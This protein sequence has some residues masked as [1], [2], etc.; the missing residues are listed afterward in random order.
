MTEI[1]Q[2]NNPEERLARVFALAED[3]YGDPDDA[4]VFMQEVHS[5]HMASAMGEEGG[6]IMP[7]NEV[8][9]GADG[10]RKVVAYLY[11]NDIHTRLKRIFKDN[12]EAA[13]RFMDK[14]H[15]MLDMQK[16]QD[17]I[18]SEAGYKQVKQILSGAEAGFA[19]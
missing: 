12:A 4:E 10:T 2:I 9:A 5:G 8:K 1:W 13:M 14:P 18:D 17:V 15:A 16:P 11:R 19:V 6:I 3:V 7:E